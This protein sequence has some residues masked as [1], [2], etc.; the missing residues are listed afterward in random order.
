MVKVQSYSRRNGT[1]YTN[2]PSGRIKKSISILDSTEHT[3][4]EPI[5]RMSRDTPNILF[6]LVAVIIICKKNMN[7]LKMTRFAHNKLFFIRDRF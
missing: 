4:Y 6:H 5:T 3:N 2:Q 1:L 7:M